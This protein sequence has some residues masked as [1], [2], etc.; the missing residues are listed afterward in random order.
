MRTWLHLIGSVIAVASLG[1]CSSSAPLFVERLDTNT[2]VTVLNAT[3]PLVLYRDNS[4]YAAHA[5][6]YVYMGPIEVNNMG[7]ESYYLWLGIW[8]TMRDATRLADQRDGFESVVL[9]ADG[10]PMPLEIAGWTLDTI[11]V[12]EPVYTRPVAGAADAYY[13]V[14]ADQIRLITDARDVELRTGTAR[15]VA[16]TLWDQQSLPSTSLQA[17]VRRARN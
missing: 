9:Y 16:Y 4:G 6:D 7:T 17:F 10:E 11:G 5:R 12:S 2:G 8:S 15:E 3:E 14:T 13:R 1:A